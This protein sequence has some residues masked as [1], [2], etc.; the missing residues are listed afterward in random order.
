M[1]SDD[2]SI[3]VSLA[4]I[5]G[6]LKREFNDVLVGI[7]LEGSFAWG[8]AVATSDLDLRVV[9]SA[10]PTEIQRE[11]LAAIKA[12]GM[13]NLGREVG[14]TLDLITDLLRV[15][16]VRFQ[17]SRH[18]A[19]EDIRARVPLKSIDAFTRDSLSTACRLVLELRKMHGGIAEFPVGP[20]LAASEFR[21]FDTQRI[22]DNGRWVVSSKRLVTNV[23][24]VATAHVALMA[25]SYV[26]TKAEV[27]AAYANSVGDEWSAFVA[28]VSEVCR[29]KWAY[30]LPDDVHDRALLTSLCDSAVGF[31]NTLSNLVGRPTP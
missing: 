28:K 12:E 23:M 24:A 7:Y 16:A 15:G 26:Y 11:R 17:R 27:P 5:V 30:R 3:D 2:N 10:M 19:G 18:L 6:A 9:T 4:A 25:G 21:G 29:G 13:L 22:L 20:P 8:N 31:E 1:A 14:I